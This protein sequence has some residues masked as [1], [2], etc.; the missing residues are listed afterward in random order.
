MF[1]VVPRSSDSIELPTKSGIVSILLRGE[2]L[3]GCLGEA[4]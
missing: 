1:G 3:G 4:V 2:G